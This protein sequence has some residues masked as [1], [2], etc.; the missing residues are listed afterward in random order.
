M[1][2]DPI[3]SCRVNDLINHIF[4]IK[5]GLLKSNFGIV[6]E[7]V[8]KWSKSLRWTC[9]LISWVID[10]NPCRCWKGNAPTRFV[11]NKIGRSI[12][13]F[14]FWDR[15]HNKLAL[16]IMVEFHMFMLKSCVNYITKQFKWNHDI[17]VKLSIMG[18][19]CV[20]K[21]Q[22]LKMLPWPSIHHNSYCHNIE[23]LQLNDKRNC[24]VTMW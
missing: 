11:T 14:L 20:D 9:I 23:Y 22:S 13:T 19:I 10:Q 3:L 16:V 8:W 12:I 24:Q 2:R 18:N 17:Q 6:K 15:G 7:L 21:Y 4:F 5:R 1:T